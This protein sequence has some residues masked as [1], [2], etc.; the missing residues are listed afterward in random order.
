MFV[1]MVAAVS[2]TE[3][4]AQSEIILMDKFKSGGV[5]IYIKSSYSPKTIKFIGVSLWRL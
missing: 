4:L 5:F 2:H 3:Y 1:E